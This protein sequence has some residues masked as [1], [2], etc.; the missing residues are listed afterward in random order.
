MP[1]PTSTQNSPINYERAHDLPGDIPPAH[2]MLHDRKANGNAPRNWT[3]L[4]YMAADNEEEVEAVQNINE[5]EI[6]GSTQ[7]VNIIVYVDF[8]SN[9]TTHEQFAYTFNITKQ[10]PANQTIIS[11]PL[12][13]S[14]PLEPNMGD[15][16][17]LLAFIQFGQNISQAENYLLILWDKGTGYPGVCYDE[18]SGGDRLLPQEIALVLNNET[19]DPIAITAFDASF[20]GQLELTYEIREGTDFIVFSEE[21]VP[22]QHFP[23]QS[24]LLSLTLIEDSSPQSLAIEIVDRY[25]EAYSPGG[26]YYS[27]FSPPPSTLCL[28]VINTSQINRVFTFFRNTIFWLNSSYNAHYFY[29][30]I[31]KARGLTQQFIVPHYIDLGEFAHQLH[32][33]VLN[34]E[35]KNYAG[36]LSLSVQEAV[37]YHKHLSG[38][39]GASGLGINF[40]YYDPVFLSLRNDTAYDDFLTKFLTIGETQETTILTLSLGPF[41]GYLDGKGDSV[42]YRFT[43]EIAAE[44]VIVT[45]AYQPGDNDFDLYLYDSNWNVLT[46]SVGLTSEETVQ[47]AL[48]PGL[49]YYLRVYSTDRSEI[50]S[51]LGV[52]EVQISPN[53]PINPATIVLQIG[54]IIAIICIVAVILVSIWR[55]WNRIQRAIERYRLRRMAK[56]I[57]QEASLESGTTPAQA[58]CSKC[59]AMLPADAKFCPNCGE[60]FEESSDEVSN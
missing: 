26:I 15:P 3:V 57:Q 50:S 18:T 52:F 13:T 47:W 37:L 31:S 41:A 53:T 44:H 17:T 34:S 60:T 58:K 1:L 7:Q 2:A 48:V 21:T 43:P 59:E 33:Q 54:I 22:S 11:E 20:M 28:S 42:Y 16:A 8:R 46:R 55:N 12:N 49:I 35:F 51:G 45:S 32:T 36:N 9:T 40:D 24:F 4:V 25:A 14:L 30:A 38:A 27:A 23:Y 6:V 29:S 10:D 39:P 5:M 56:R 19:I